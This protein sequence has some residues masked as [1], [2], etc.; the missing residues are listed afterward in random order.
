MRFCLSS[1]PEMYRALKPHC[2]EA[3]NSEASS[4]A[5]RSLIGLPYELTV[6]CAD[7]AMLLHL[8]VHSC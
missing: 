1:E 6:L 4:F 7:S 8:G 2:F 3:L 5:G